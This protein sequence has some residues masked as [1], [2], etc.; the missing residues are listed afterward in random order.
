MKIKNDFVTNSSSTCYVFWG[1][2]MEIYEAKD[3]FKFSEDDEGD[4]LDGF[5]WDKFKEVG[6]DYGIW[7]DADMVYLG[8]DPGRMQ[9]DETK[10]EFK[11]KILSGLKQLG[12]DL[13]YEDIH[14][15]KEASMD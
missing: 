13:K 8:L 9:E 7:H 14:Y 15:I 6:L 10:K 12:F 3:H 5:L 2:S 11:L 4:D 1:I